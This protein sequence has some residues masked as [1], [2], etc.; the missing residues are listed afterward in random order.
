MNDVYVEYNTGFV[1]V[2]VSKKIIRNGLIAMGILFFMYTVAF[3]YILWTFA[4]L[5]FVWAYYYNKRLKYEYEYIVCNNTFHVDKIIN[6]L[7]RK[8]AYRG[9]LNYMVLFTNSSEILNNFIYKTDKPVHKKRFNDP[10]KKTYA[11]VLKTDRGYDVLYLNG[12][13]EFVDAIAR[14]HPR[15]TVMKDLPSSR[16]AAQPAVQPQEN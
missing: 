7:K 6:N 1:P 10:R 16:T 8:K 2:P 12:N 9:D 5:F 4:L 3:Y 14:M 15:E 11:M 13:E